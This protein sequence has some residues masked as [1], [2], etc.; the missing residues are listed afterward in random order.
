LSLPTTSN[1]EVV[2]RTQGS[3]SAPIITAPLRSSGSSPPST[4]GLPMHS[5]FR[6]TSAS[7]S[8]ALY[9][10][11]VNSPG[12]G[13]DPYSPGS[14]S[15]SVTLGYA[16]IDSTHHP[17]GLAPEARRE[18]PFP[19]IS[20]FRPASS[21][22]STTHVPGQSEGWPEAT[23]GQ[24][25]YDIPRHTSRATPPPLPA[26]T[27]QG[28]TISSTGD[29]SNPV[30]PPASLLPLP[31]SSKSNLTLPQPVPSGHPQRPPPVPLIGESRPG[32]HGPPLPSI[33]AAALP[34]SQGVSNWPALLRASELA[35]EADM[36]GKDTMPERR[37]QAP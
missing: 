3:R 22:H 35:R 14:S 16:S 4:S 17:R 6:R 20:P 30:L 26:L 8:P 34:D 5:G 1:T 25:S 9:S 29:S 36:K 13:G 18:P 12:K 10:D 31:E 33:S 37:R 19:P 21:S 15:P 32:S 27:R 28:S 24:P 2:E 23:H 11:A 7:A